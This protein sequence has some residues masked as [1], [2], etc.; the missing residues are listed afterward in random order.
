VKE[1][2]G[3]KR[4]AETVK[5]WVDCGSVGGGVGQLKTGIQNTTHVIPG[6]PCVSLH[7]HFLVLYIIYSPLQPC[8]YSN[9][10]VINSIF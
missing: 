4:C 6:Y 1:Y 9:R 10:W 8:F 3:L 5:E 2:V 7:L